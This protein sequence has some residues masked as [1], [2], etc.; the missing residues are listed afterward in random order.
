MPVALARKL[1]KSAMDIGNGKTQ[2]DQT[3]SRRISVLDMGNLVLILLL[4]GILGHLRWAKMDT[5]VFGDTPR[6][7]FEAQRVAVGQIPYRDF[8]WN[9]PPLS[10]FLLGWFMRLFGVSFAAAQTFIDIASTCV[11]LAL[12][13]LVRSLLPRFLRLPVMFCLL[14]VCGTSLMF[15]NLFSLMTYV[16]ALQIAVAGFLLFLVGV[17]NYIAT[18]KMKA[19][20]WLMVA[21]GA[22]IAAY[23]KP[24]TF[25]AT[26]GTFLVLAIIDRN[27][28]FAGQNPRLWLLHYTKVAVVSAGP[29][30]VAYLW[31]G[32]VAGFANMMAGITGYGLAGGTCPWWPTGLG[33]FGAASSLGEAVFI[34]SA[35]SLL[36]R[37][38]FLARL[39]RSYYYILSGGLA[40][41]CV[42]LGYIF[43]NNWELLTGS[44]SIIDKV[45]Y[46]GQS[47]FWTS[48]ALLPVMWSCVV[49][50]SYLLVRAFLLREQQPSADCFL[51]LVLLTG[52]VLMSVRGWFNW[53]LGLRTDVPGVCYTFFLMLGPCLLWR[54]LTF[55]ESRREL[56]A[57]SRVAAGI[58]VAALLFIYGALRVIAAYPHLLSNRPYHELST[59][60]GNI[61]LTEYKT[62]SEIYRFVVENT[63]ANDLVLDLPYGGGINFAA[64][65]LSPLFETQ[66]Q[67][68]SMPDR[69]L[70]KDL[71]AVREHP[72]RVVIGDDGP[73]Y[74]ASYGL[75]SNTCVFPH[76]V[77][78]PHA[79][80]LNDKSFPA[81]VFIE[82]NYRV[83]EVVGR[84][85]LLAPK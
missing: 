81:I 4:C 84:K 74:G 66:F 63:S 48:A 85:L 77:W 59:L 22:F 45:W 16:P 18:G 3:G 40:G 5:L 55:E 15:F 13:F 80:S 36:R 32:A 54:T 52:P 12:Y 10:V 60:A 51:L 64:H 37:K 20:D 75:K 79:S 50:W 14:A 68:L 6:W 73:N 7:L 29:M 65:R 83:A 30:L 38:H 42:Y 39:G 26:Y 82:R 53:N 9:Y 78:A 70:E 44:R 21:L 76:F 24:E 23:S 46:S 35:L 61:R 28:W 31:T 2:F 1:I 67:Q 17:L 72:P 8:S 34:I 56:H 33:I 25:I 47:T 58:A 41:A 71:Q 57:N 43:F 62:D 69:F 19:T 49:L 27:Y 11:I